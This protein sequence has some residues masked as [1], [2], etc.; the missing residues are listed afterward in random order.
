[1]R[2]T[3]ESFET[4]KQLLVTS[5][6][7]IINE[8]ELSYDLTKEERIAYFNNFNEKRTLLNRFEAKN[9]KYYTWSEGNIES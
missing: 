7:I 8:L 5:C 9:I 6:I 1:M 3:P 4:I 2:T